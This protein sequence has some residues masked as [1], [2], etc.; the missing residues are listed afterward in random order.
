MDNYFSR[1]KEGGAVAS[2]GFQYQDLCA[3]RYFF[4]YVDNDE[5]VSLT[6]EQIE[7]FS[8][9]LKTKE[10]IFQIKDY[11]LHKKEINEILDMIEDKKDVCNYIVAPCW[12][13][14]IATIIQKK[15]EYMNACLA[16]RNSKQTIEIEKQLIDIIKEKEYS[17]KA[18][19]CKFEIV[20]KEEQE[21]IILYRINKWIR[22][23]NYTA[24]EEIVFNQLIS[25]VQEQR[26]NRGS[27]NREILEYIVQNSKIENKSVNSADNKGFNKESILASL[28]VFA[29]GKNRLGELIELIIAYVENDDYKK[30]LDKLSELTSENQDANMYK[31]WVLL[32]LGKYEEVHKICDEIVRDKIEKFYPEA[33]FY[34]AVV[35]YQNKKY[36]KAYKYIKKSNDLSKQIAYDQPALLAK[37]SIKINKS[38]KESKAMLKRCIEMGSKDSDIFYE[39]ARFSKPFEAIELLNT[40]L[41]YNEENY[42]AKFLLAE[43]YRM[44]GED[45]MAYKYYKSYFT[46]FDNFE[47]WKALQG[48]VYC[49]INMGKIGEAESYILQSMYSFI[50]SSDNV[51][52][53]HQT[54]ILMDLTWNRINLLICTKENN[55]YLFK[56]PLGECSIPEKPTNKSMKEKDRIGVFPDFFLFAHELFMS[57]IGDKKINIENIIKPAFVANYDDEYTFFRMKNE[58]VKN[59]II[60]L[61]HEKV[62]KIK[63]NNLKNIFYLLKDGDELHYLEYMVYEKDVEISIYEYNDY[64]RVVSNFG[65]KFAEVSVFQKGEGYFNFKKVLERSKFISWYYFL[66]TRKEL[67]DL[68]IPSENV[69]I[70]YC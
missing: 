22:K 1:R 37:V 15:K 44:V 42:K 2:R 63:T 8:V 13:S 45:E 65:K 16:G 28:R 53:D 57:K 27:I 52:K 38:V 66:I 5:F 12:N 35:N 67:I 34:E 17:L 64:I 62:E 39:L 56:S 20:N 46:E 19:V 41:E 60:W 9:L 23:H 14:S 26:S 51:I 21:E 6:L 68:C 69:K 50:D 29:R 11:K 58:L 59:K 54:A 33:Y 24:N 31:A 49:L 47:N 7:D 25:I 43:N 4:D 30:A 10:I 18:R 32:Q 40:S 70:I 61:N 48:I 55:M 36:K 3:V